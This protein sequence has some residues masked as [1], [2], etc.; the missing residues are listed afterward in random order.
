LHIRHI[1]TG[2][3]MLLM[4]I[5]VDTFRDSSIYATEAAG[6][7]TEQHASLSDTPRLRNSRQPAGT[8]RREQGLH[9]FQ[10]KSGVPTLT[11]VPGKYRSQGNFQEINISYERVTVPQRYRNYTSPSQYVNEDIAA[12]VSQY[13]GQYGVNENLIYAIMKME[14][15]GNINAVSHVGA[16]G[17]M[18]LMP[19]TAAEMGVTDI[20][21]PAQNIAGGTQYLARMLE[22]FNGDLRLALAGYNA[23]P[24]AVRRHGGIPPFKETQ[25]YVERVTTYFSSLE[26]GNPNTTR[27]TIRQL[28]QNAAAQAALRQD[29]HRYVVHFNSGLTQ[30]ADSVEDRDPYYYIEY[31][32]RVYPVRKDLVKKVVEPANS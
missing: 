9:E 21:D 15:N 16:S 8:A 18:Q 29:T 10:D 26:G 24:E 6:N 5:S 11:N 1:N 17:L 28:R 3:L 22:L 20:F 13:A 25:T 19:G 23:G 12:L 31:G 7:R 27:P 4:S 30:P 14:S 32:R 2:L